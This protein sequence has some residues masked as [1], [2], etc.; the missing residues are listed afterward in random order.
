[1]AV[2]SKE[3]KIKKF[4]QRIEKYSNNPKIQ[5]KLEGKLAAL[6]GQK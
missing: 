5:K 6:K 2:R 4:K 1:M 3:N